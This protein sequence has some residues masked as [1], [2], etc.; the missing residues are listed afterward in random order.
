MKHSMINSNYKGGSEYA[1]ESFYDVVI[2]GAGPAGLACAKKLKNSKLKV[3]IIEKNKIIGPKICAGGLCG[4][5]DLNFKKESYF[6]SNNFDIYYKK[7][8]SNIKVK[9]KT[10]F[11][12]MSRTDLGNFQLNELSNSKLA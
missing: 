4:D 11:K 7:V 12:I 6:Y 8:K 10:G 1:I 2:V 9:S 5:Y 3:L